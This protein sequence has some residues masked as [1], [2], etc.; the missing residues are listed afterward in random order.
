VLRAPDPASTGR[1]SGMAQGL[2]YLLAATGPV[3]VGAVHD[4]TRSWTA[5]LWLLVALTVPGAIAGILAGRPRQ[6]SR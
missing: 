5:P 4:V 1:L 2:G 6:I 3:L